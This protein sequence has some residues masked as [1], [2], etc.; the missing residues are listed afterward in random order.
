MLS[1]LAA[2][3]CRLLF[4]DAKMGMWLFNAVDDHL[5]RVP[6]WSATAEVALWDAAD[7]N[8]F[9]LSDGRRL[10]LFLHTPTSLSGAG[11]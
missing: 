1:L 8:V 5:L 3:T 4:E 6:E 10:G 9:L 7:L 2:A 11:D